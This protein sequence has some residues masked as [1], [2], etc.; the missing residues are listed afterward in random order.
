[1]LG[2]ALSF[3][4]LH[5]GEGSRNFPRDDHS[6]AERDYSRKTRPSVSSLKIHLQILTRLRKLSNTGAVGPGGANPGKGSDE[7]VLGPDTWGCTSSEC[8]TVGVNRLV[9]SD[10][11]VAEKIAGG[12]TMSRSAGMS[13]MV[14]RRSSVRWV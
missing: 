5:N 14:P 3:A 9:G 8:C 12:T 10:V 2:S 4:P 1:M 7:G 11:R 13:S 6:G